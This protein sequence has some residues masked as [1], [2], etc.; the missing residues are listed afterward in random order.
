MS[1]AVL[2]RF[3]RYVAFDTQSDPASETAPSSA[4]QLKLAEALVSE[5]SALGVADA[6][7]GHGGIVYASLPATPG[8][9]ACPALGF[10]SHM[11]TAPDASG[12]NVNPQ[13]RRFD[14]R[15]VVLNAEKHIIFSVETF[16]EIK[17]YAGEDIIFTDGTTLLGADD[18]AGIASIMTT[19]EWLQQ[20]PETPHAKIYIAFTPDEEIGRGT[21]NLDYSAFAA[22]YAYTIDGGEIGGLE[23]ETFNAASAVLTVKGVGV[24]TGSAK[25]KM[26]NALR[27]AAKFV[28]SLPDDM[29]PEHTEGY[30]GFLHAHRMEGDVVESRVTMLI[31]D[32]DKTKFEAKKAYLKKHAEDLK[33]ANPGAVIE[34][35]IKDTYENMR[36]YLEKAPKVL[37]IARE[38]Y[39]AVGLTPVE[40]PIRGGTDGAVMS[41]HGLPCPNV[42][43]GGLNYHGIFEYLP[44]KSLEKAAEVTL[45]IAKRSA[46]VRSLQ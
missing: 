38:A 16:P 4:K 28:A 15:D 36:P 13:I 9:E 10:S 31:R 35:T 17:K 24:H 33:A 32:H 19:V 21:E 43:T 20:H 1:S 42:F 37:E 46:Q 39:R 5:L 29:T 41:A 7:L 18:K 2:D 25:N 11:D 8:C 14:G 40:E 3:L 22:Q 12:L 30:E 27:C 34:L 6:H 44:V 45:E 26:V 23:S